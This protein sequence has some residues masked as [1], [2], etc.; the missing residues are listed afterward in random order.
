[1]ANVD[2]PFGFR[3]IKHLNGAEFNEQVNEYSILASNSDKL[4]IG[5]L[6]LLGGSANSDG[7]P[8]IVKAQGSEGTPDDNLLGAIVA[9]PADRDNQ[10][11]TN[12]PASTAGTVLVSDSPDLI[13]EA[14]VTTVAVT[15]F[16][17]IADIVTGDGSDTTGNSIGEIDAATFGSGGQVRVLRLKRIDGVDGA[18]EVG[19]NAVVECILLN[20]Q[21]RGNSAI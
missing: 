20:P 3:P 10:G 1:M 8:N 13:Y 17:N 18:N 5:D 19:A 14:Q 15:D 12:F 4:Y 9:F 21:L 2:A 16:S 6:V 11:R 7:I